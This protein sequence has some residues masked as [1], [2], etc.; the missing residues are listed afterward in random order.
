MIL[1][2][3]ITSDRASC[4]P[5]NPNLGT[6][7]EFVLNICLVDEVRFQDLFRLTH[8][9]AGAKIPNDVF[10]TRVLQVLTANA[11]ETLVRQ[12]DD[13]DV[14]QGEIETLD[15]LAGGVGLDEVES[16]GR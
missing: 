6:G 14:A 4:S 11:A 2:L 5:G 10:F 12:R 15:A 3:L 13:V 7:S 16:L 9:G 1:G 8:P